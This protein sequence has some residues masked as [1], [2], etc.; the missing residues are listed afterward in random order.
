MH[1]SG[2]PQS[3]VVGIDGSRAAISAALWAVDEAVSRDIPLRLLYAVDH[4]DAERLEPEEAA[5]K[6]AAAEIAVRY[7][8]TAVESTE[9]PVKIEVEITQGNP[10]SSLV[11]A[12][13]SAA[14]VCVGAIG[15]R[16]FDPGRVGSTAAAVAVNAHCPVAIIRG[17][18]SPGQSHERWVVV[19]T[20][21]SPDNGVLLETAVLEARLR[22]APL[23]AVT[24]WT[25]SPGDQQTALGDGHQ[26]AR[27]DLDRRLAR[28]RRQYPDV[29]A[30]SVA[31]H[32]SILDYLA[33]NAPSV[34]LVVA[35][36]GGGHHVHELTGPPGN[37]VLHHAACSVLVVDHRHL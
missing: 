13:R 8:F 29:R 23:R 17:N 11:R 33:K 20:D 12:S 22:N 5:R 31:V 36:A 25:A 37:A 18:G 10:V 14:M 7:A 15:C 27:A 34:Q 1:E 6:L 4:A 28:W 9:K 21:A 24:C 2:T 32:G 35:D 3:I 26:R 16:H 19:E 30:E